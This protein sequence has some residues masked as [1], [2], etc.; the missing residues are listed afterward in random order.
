MTSHKWL[1]GNTYGGV[2]SPDY[3]ILSYTWGRWR[4]EDPKS[5]VEA[6]RVQNVP[7]DVPRI[8][9]THF[10]AARFRNT[11]HLI[12]DHTSS[13]SGDS[14][15]APFAWVD[16]ACIPQW[17]HSTTADS[18]VGRQA[19][20]FRRAR[21]KYVWLTDTR[22]DDLRIL[23]TSN[24]T[25][26][27]LAAFRKILAD[28]WF[29][30]MWTLQESYV[31]RTAPI[32]TRDGFCNIHWGPRTE[33]FSL[34]HVRLYATL[35]LNKENV[36]SALELKDSFTAFRETW[37]RSGLQGIQMPP[38]MQVLACARHRTCLEVLDR[39]YGIM[40]IFGSECRLGK[41]RLA[42][43]SQ[44]S[45]QTFTL[46]ELEDELG[47]YLLENIAC[48]SQLFR[49][50]E[51]PLAGRAWRIC[52]RASVPWLVGADAGIGGFGSNPASQFHGMQPSSP[53]NNRNLYPPACVLSTRTDGSITWATFRGK[54]CPLAKILTL[55]N[56]INLGPD[57]TVSHV[58]RIY[59]DYGMD[60]FTER[61]G[62]QALTMLLLTA[63]TA[64]QEP[65]MQPAVYMDALLLIEP[66]D[67]ALAV[68]RSRKGWRSELDGSGRRAW[69]RVG[70]FQFVWDLMTRSGGMGNFIETMEDEDMFDV[71]PFLGETDD[72]EEQEGIFG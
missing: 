16:V 58:S 46:Q 30:S 25:S 39:V 35:L 48:I 49:H 41:A 52:G 61:F 45:G 33:P 42:M 3:S 54:L 53:N 47:K 2:A 29:E 19:Q 5:T 62:N 1:P 55:L 8:E 38:P 36:D 21:Y 22:P 24:D 63:H 44:Q 65:L 67:Q 17:P 69:A 7:W 10:N 70:I 34:V 4:V 20:I 15:A 9:P 68:H 71:N 37:F 12:A 60:H 14:K 23:F 6:L 27:K 72:W 28:P 50:E 43:T 57:V 32:V 56:S 11:L 13:L 64:G 26:Q 40:Q 51:A 31:S 59:L 18:E 66:G